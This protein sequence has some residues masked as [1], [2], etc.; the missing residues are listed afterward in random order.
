MK[1][2]TLLAVTLSAS[3]L[4]PTLPV[5]ASDISGHWAQKP[6]EDLIARGV[7]KGTAQDTYEPNRAVNRQEFA[8]MLARLFPLK[9]AADLSTY[10]D[11][12]SS[13]WAYE[14]LA[15]AVGEGLLSG[16]STTTLSPKDALTRQDAAVILSR[17]LKSTATPDDLSRF[18]DASEVAGYAKEAMGRMVTEKILQG[19]GE[20]LAPK[21]TITRAEAAKMLLLVDQKKGPVAPVEA[22]KKAP[23]TPKVTPVAKKPAIDGYIVGLLA[24]TPTPAPKP[25]PEAP[26]PAPAPAPITPP[27]EEDKDKDPTPIAPPREE[28]KDKDPAPN[29]SPQED[30]KVIFEEETKI[31]DLGWAQYVSL[32]FTEGSLKD[33]RIFVDGTDVTDAVTPISD[34]GNLAKWELSHLQPKT[35]RVVRNQ[36]GAVQEK[37]LSDNPNPTPATLRID[38]DPY[39]ILGHGP[40]PVWDYHLTN[41]DDQ[42]FARVHPKKTTFDVFHSEKLRADAPA[43]F[44]APDAILDEHG[45]GTVEVLFSI[46]SPVE[47]AWFDGIEE[48]EQSVALLEQGPERRVLSPKLAFSKDITTHH[49]HEVGRIRVSVPQTNMRNAGRYVLRIASTSHQSAFV[50]IHVLNHETFTLQQKG[51]GRIE[52][53]DRIRFRVEGLTYGATFPIE[54][55]LLIDPEGTSHNLRKID[56][57]YLLSD[58]LVLY[59]DDTT[60]EGRNNIPLKG[61]YTLKVYATGYQEV[62]T[63]FRVVSG[64]EPSERRTA[65]RV[66]AMT[67]ATSIGV[68]PS[69]DG[70]GGGTVA[71][72]ADL[73]FSGDL[74][75]NAKILNALGYQDEHAKSISARFDS[76]SLDRV[77]AKT[78]KD[79]YDWTSYVDAVQQAAIGGVYL[80]FADYAPTGRVTSNPHAFK[81]VL[82]DNLL[83]EVQYSHD[84]GV[85]P[86]L[87]YGLRDGEKTSTFPEGEDLV[88]ETVDSEYFSHLSSIEVSG[89]PM[90]LQ[91]GDYQIEG[92]RLTIKEEA[93]GFGLL[94][95]TLKADGYRPLRFNVDHA[96]NLESIKL[97][98]D[99][100]AYVAGSDRVS[101]RIEGS[102]GDFLSHLKSI[103]LRSPSEGTIQ[104]YDAKTGGTGGNRYYTSTGTAITIMEG[105]FDR[106]GTYEITIDAEHYGARSVSV[107][108][109]RDRQD[110]PNTNPTVKREGELYVLD[111]ESSNEMKS[112]LHS[113]EKLSVNGRAYEWETSSDKVT[114]SSFNYQPRVYNGYTILLG[115]GALVPG[116]KNTVTITGRGNKPFDV[117]LSVDES[118]T[119]PNPTTEPKEKPEAPKEKPIPTSL[120][121]S[122]SPQSYDG[123]QVWWSR[124]GAKADVTEYLDHLTSVT[125]NG[126]TYTESDGNPFGPSENHYYLYNRT[127]QYMEFDTD[128]AY[129]RGQEN[130]IVL[131]AEGYAPW[132]IRIASDG[133]VSYQ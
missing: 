35:L 46:G 15:L 42:G 14:P 11:I 104:I 60:P 90:P 16:T 75:A 27:R 96:K 117:V 89:T 119:D 25:A 10:R 45:S 8:A 5:W 24:P 57:Y 71:M 36:D 114:T 28:D 13:D 55:V 50:P 19:D 31:H 44:Y 34:D 126:V 30:P 21:R 74:I 121:W 124:T 61:T 20:S 66:D 48:R 122:K 129:K 130:V 84:R 118:K 67:R 87:V 108:V 43:P 49:N 26:K 47:R 86:P 70:S 41:Y 23:E 12:K 83:G 120:A 54:K 73:A 18:S 109:N 125:L 91:D 53:G 78:M 95:F 68:T 29:P 94:E 111:F 69:P 127:S 1:K 3:L 59:N 85:E 110:A 97:V 82:E 80:P 131:K 88:F 132:T 106:P 40:I 101:I 133:T 76:L 98:P 7:L 37:T 17:L 115:G 113:I 93:I 77:Y 51:S 32:R 107:L 103:T 52:S 81:E 112:W 64:K 116:E 102:K 65:P 22:P 100:A 79:A 4:A 128:S 72:S 123:L 63:Q 38:T 62:S 56:D 99:K 33:H 92:N 58:V 39:L 105:Y 6:M 9:K 2:R